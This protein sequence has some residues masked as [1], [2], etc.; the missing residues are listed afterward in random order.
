[1]VSYILF[2]SC[3]RLLTLFSFR[4]VEGPFFFPLDQPVIQPSPWG[5]ADTSFHLG[6][7]EVSHWENQG[8]QVANF[9]SPS[10][11]GNFPPGAVVSI[12]DNG[13]QLASFNPA[14]QSHEL[15]LND[16]SG[17]DLDF[18]RAETQLTASQYQVT[19]P[20]EPGDLPGDQSSDFDL[21]LGPR[22]HRSPELAPAPISQGWTNTRGD[23]GSNNN[24]HNHENNR[25]YK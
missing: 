24:G 10:I 7:S 2:L 18:G 19:V 8:Q 9:A 6:D 3:M 20:T 16:I 25:R 17:I 11:P 14:D 1:M 4:Y 13:S 21:T 15:S 5:H 12:P 23:Q 22:V